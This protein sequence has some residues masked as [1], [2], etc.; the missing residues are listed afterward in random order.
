MAKQFEI[1][2]SYLLV[3]GPNVF[4]HNNLLNVFQICS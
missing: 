1:R 3:L 2:V 4:G